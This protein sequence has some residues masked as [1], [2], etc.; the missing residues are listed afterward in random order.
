MDLTSPLSNTEAGNRLS[1]VADSTQVNLNIVNN[2]KNITNNIIDGNTNSMHALTPEQEEEM[3][4]RI[5]Y[6]NQQ[7]TGGSAFIQKMLHKGNKKYFDSGDYNMAKSK[8]KS[9]N[10]QNKQMLI[11]QSNL[12]NTNNSNS[13]SCN[14]SNTDVSLSPA[15]ISSSGGDLN[16]P[17]ILIDGHNANLNITNANGSENSLN[18][19]TNTNA[20]NQTPT[21]NTN[22]HHLNQ[23]PLSSISNTSNLVSPM[24]SNSISSS[25]LSISL[26]NATLIPSSISTQSISMITSSMSNEKL[27]SIQI[28][29]T[30]PSDIL[31]SEEIGHGIPTPECL[32]QSRKHS[33][34]K[35]KLATPRLSSVE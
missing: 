13:N 1:S 23:T 24:L 27:T 15:S 20:L 10:P 29:T 35:S 28:N 4:L 18:N 6:P 9:L 19:I 32:P 26:N 5:K 21:M 2:D 8:S 3:K 22:N 16:S 33:I 30:N 34:V 25:S 12:S 11:Q 31:D 17:N 14:N 7:K